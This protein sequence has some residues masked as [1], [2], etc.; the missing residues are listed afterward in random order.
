VIGRLSD[1]ATLGTA[2]TLAAIAAMAADHLMGADPG[3]E[4]PP[5]FLLS[6][7][8]CLV[9]AIALFGVVIPRTPP[10]RAGRRGFVFSLL[11][12]LTLP[13]AFLGVFFVFAGA[14]IALGR[15]GEGRLATA[16]LAIGSVLAVLG[17][18]GYA[19]VAISKL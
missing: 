18:A 5:A 16:A 14:G 8:V 17:T 1:T 7:G 9:V 4:D 19:Y 12:V 13:L 15:I 2:A 6:A 10:E 3:L 11:G